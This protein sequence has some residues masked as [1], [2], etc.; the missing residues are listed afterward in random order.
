MA[1]SNAKRGLM[2]PPSAGRCGTFRL[3]QRA[4]RCEAGDGLSGLVDGDAGRDLWGSLSIGV[5]ALVGR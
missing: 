5:A 1:Y 2:L 3:G 4:G